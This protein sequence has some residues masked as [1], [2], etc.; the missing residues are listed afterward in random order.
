MNDY[1]EL[2]PLERRILS[3]VDAGVADVEIGRRFRRSPAMVR[4][5][6]RLTEIERA[7]ATTASPPP[8]LR[9]LERRVLRWRA[10]GSDY[11]DIGRRFGRSPDH[12]RRVEELAHY[13]LQST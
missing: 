4:R 13:K 1:S 2:R 10:E 5:I 11:V 8:L 3:F 7:E 6:I 12:V 9:P